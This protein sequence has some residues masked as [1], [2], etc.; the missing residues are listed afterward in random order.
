MN[1]NWETFEHDQT[2]EAC[3]LNATSI[4]GEC[5]QGSVPTVGVDARVPQDVIAAV[6]FATTH[7]LKV[8]VKSTG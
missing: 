5:K 4:S 2:I 8:V 7:R 1:V 3:Y 6:H